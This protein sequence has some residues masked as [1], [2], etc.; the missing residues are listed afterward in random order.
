MRLS[1]P[2]FWL[3]TII[4]FAAGTWWYGS[5]SKCTTCD[6]S[7]TTVTENILLPRFNVTD[8]N[9]N[10]SSA[11]NLKFGKS[12]N[13]PV[14]ST[15]I[16]TVLDSVALYAKNN[17]GKTITITGH[18]KADEVNT[19]AFENLGLARADELKKWM[20]NKGVPEAGIL[21]K[22]Q[23]S[24]SLVFSPSDTLVGGI[25]ML[26]NNAEA[27][28]IATPQ[29]VVED[30]FQPR[31]VY[32][33]TGKNTLPVDTAFTN[34]IEKVKA[35]LQ[36]NTDKKLMVTGYTDNVGDA[37]KNLQLSANRASFIKSELVKQGIADERMESNGKGMN[38]PVSDN[39]TAEGR[40]KNRRVT[41]QLQ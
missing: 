16:T 8:S 1:K 36:S 28:V 4:W 7:V 10:V 19:T 38:D 32:F 22:S 12:G 41:I 13:I 24:E 37:E 30:L 23:L 6:A 25:S 39:T 21:T 5:C 2:L 15:E 14:I 9:W 29:P 33:N 17:P 11:A 27:Q 31:T 26:F 40:A 18:Y 20:I 34:Y 35:Y 3:L